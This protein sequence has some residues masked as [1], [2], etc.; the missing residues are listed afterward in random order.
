MRFIYVSCS[1][2]ALFILTD[3][4]ADAE[5][6]LSYPK[7]VMLAL[8][9]SKT[10]KLLHIS[11]RPHDKNRIKC[12]QLKV[13]IKETETFP[14]SKI[15]EQIKETWEKGK[16]QEYQ[17]E[18]C[19]NIIKEFPLLDEQDIRNRM[20][21][22]VE[23]KELDQKKLMIEWGTNTFFAIRE[24][25]E[26]PVTQESTANFVFQMQEQTSL[27]CNIDWMPDFEKIYTLD[28]ANVNGPTGWI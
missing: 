23:E 21:N 6:N 25:C 28:Q 22:G 4:K 8:Q 19:S 10:P 26:R 2:L 20:S 3:I 15:L 14:Y 18:L 1:I 24:A 7:S 11:C 9:D 17:R 16:M 5:T 27:I 12:R 13:G